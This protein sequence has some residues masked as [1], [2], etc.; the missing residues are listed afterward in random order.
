MENVRHQNMTKPCFRGHKN[1]YGASTDRG[2]LIKGRSYPFQEFY[3]LPQRILR[4]DCM[5]KLETE[6]PGPGH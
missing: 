5:D 6:N 3:F 2:G 1:L 4:S